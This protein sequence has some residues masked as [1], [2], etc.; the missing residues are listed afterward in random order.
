[1]VIPVA[2]CGEVDEE[3]KF[4]GDRLKMIRGKRVLLRP[5]QTADWATFEIWGRERES[6]W[7]PYQ[8]FQLDHLPSLRQAYE[9]TAL[10]TRESGFLLI[11]TIGDSRLIGFVRYTF[12]PFPDS[13]LPHPE[14]GFGIPEVNARGKGFAQEAVAL[15]VDYLFNGYPFE[16]ISAFTEVENLPARNLL[17]S[18]GFY[19]EGS[20][21]RGIFRDGSWRDIALYGIL[22]DEWRPG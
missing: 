5:V 8:R 21:R 20:L 9:R 1:L 15:L 19:Q 10:L 17:S 3:N 13:E 11:E 7:G 16:R 6:L 22:R 2:N 12:I 14:I 4:G 18:L